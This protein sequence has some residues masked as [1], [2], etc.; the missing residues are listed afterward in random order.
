VLLPLLTGLKAFQYPS[1]LHAKQI[2][3][4]IKD[5][6]ASILLATDTFVNQYA[7]VAE[8]DELAGLKFIV[9]GAEKVR[10]ETHN[11][12]RERF[13]D[14]PVLE[15]YGA[16]EAAPVIAVNKPT[17]N[18]RGTVGGLL[19]GVETRLEAVEGIPGGRLYVRGPN[20]MSGYLGADGMLEPPPDGWHDT[21]DVVDI[22][23][24][25]WVKILGR[26]KR[27]AKVGGEMVSLTA[28]EDLASAVWPDSRHAVIAM[29]D[30][31][32]GERLVLV[33][34]QRD[35]DSGPLVA[36]AQA[37]GAPELAVPR[38]IIRAPEIPVL[39]TGKTDY[40]AVQRIAEA[41]GRRAA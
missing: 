19:P 27:F 22:T 39:G 33:T 25:G 7:R 13:G 23:H 3:P 40:V 15:G 12:I 24:D 26:V 37:I 5:A 2:P 16:T 11:L 29:P 9:C 32:K 38:K 41:E 31:K 34:D 4:L 20:V 14:V 35:A 18:R 17:D 36:H 8:R 1:P 28:A 10:E 30:P 6:K 21:G